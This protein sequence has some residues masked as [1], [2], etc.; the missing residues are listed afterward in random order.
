MKQRFTFKMK[1][2]NMLCILLSACML[3]G[4]ANA[5]QQSRA[6]SGV[7]RTSTDGALVEGVSVAVKGADT[8]AATDASGRY[9]INVSGDNPVLVFT[10]VGYQQQ[11]VA[12]N[13]RQVVDVSLVPLEEML[14]EVVV[15]A[16]GIEREKK[17]LGYSVG[18]VQG[19]DM[20]KVAQENIFGGLSAKLPGVTLN[21]TSGPGSSVSMIIRGANSL[22]TDNQPLFVIDGVPVSSGLN[23]QRQM[24]DRNIVD[25]G[26]A[27]SDINPDDIESISVLK[28]PSAAALYGSRAGNGVVLITTKSGRKGERTTVNFSTSNVFEQPVKFLDFHYMYASGNRG[29]LLDEGSAYWTGLPLDRGITAVQWNSPL[30][31]NGVPIPTELRSYKDNMKNFLRTGITS[32][33]NLSVSGGGERSSYRLSFNNMSHG[34]M[35]PN[36][37][38][39]RN[40]LSAVL[41]YELNSKLKLSTNINLARSNS[42]NRPTT[43]NRT[44]NPLDA[45]MAYPHVNILELRDY[46]QQGQEDIQQRSVHNNTDNPYFLAY[47]LNN[48]FVRDRVYGNIKLDWNISPEF[49][50]FGRV[51]LDKSNENR[52][53][54]MP[55]S[56][57]RAAQGGYY[58]QDIASAELNTDFLVTYRKALADVDLSFSGGGNYMRQTYRDA[59]MGGAALTIPGLYRISNVPANQLQYSNGTS[60]RAIYSLYA[61]G[62]IGYRGMLYLDLTARNDWASSL[63]EDGLSFFYP[64]ASLS[65]LANETFNLPKTVSLL[66]FRAGWAQVGNAPGAY[67]IHQ[68]LGTGLYGNLITSSVPADLRNPTLKP[69]IATSAEFGVDLNLYNNRLRFEGT[70][71]NVGNKN[72]QLPIPLPESSGFSST[73]VNAGLIVSKGWELSLG[74]TPIQNSSWTWDVNANFYRNRTIVEE[75]TEG[76]PIL[77]MWSD[78]G[79]GSFAREGERLGNLYSRGYA[80]VDDPSSPYYR[81]PILTERGEYIPVN[82]PDSRMLV[83]NYNPDFQVGLQTTLQ[84]KRF[85]LGLSFD[86]RHGG[87]FMSFT[88]RYG[89]SDWKS[90]RQ[91]RELIPGGLYDEADLAAML[92]SDPERYIIP[93]NGHFPRVGGYE[94][95]TGGY[96]NDN[97]GSPNQAYDGAFIPGVIANGDGTYREHLGGPGTVIYPVSNLFPWSYNQAVTFDASFIKLREVTLGYDIPKLWGLRNAR[98]SVFSRNIVLWT[99][100]KIGIDPERAFQAQSGVQGNTSTMYRQ[101]IEL[102]NIMPMTMPVGFKLDVTF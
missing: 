74:G 19:E 30:D 24:G 73:F 97:F 101:G 21:E 11:E 31:E 15:T 66:K 48:G 6:V 34:G 40:S 49:S 84:Y 10:S 77:T 36:S 93:R 37:N 56:Y 46:W 75:L 83:G 5:Q 71:Y 70:Y 26:N 25:Y 68:M 12:V 57:S 1:W 80:F 29:N 64:S 55:K 2:A 81:W 78:N 58:L 69:E 18:V 88:Y 67:Q 85:S 94:Q 42:D 9:T 27:I 22:T 102:Q 89:G 38:L 98:V 39:Q 47:E 35:I 72:Q 82:D 90:A 54:K 95:S 59:Y 62:S 4:I 16:L 8:R 76:F 61:M 51:A 100:A 14:G 17:S 53:T 50:A 52:E 65:W 63:P 91:M 20:V 60:D 86:W 99:A 28:G 87:Q 44:A 92:R 23:N 43:A 96:L 7:V 3:Q 32:T 79:G 45:V 13:N 33:N 41:A